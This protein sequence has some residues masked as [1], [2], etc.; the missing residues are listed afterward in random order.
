MSRNFDETLPQ[1]RTADLVSALP[2]QGRARDRQ[3]ADRRLHMHV[4]QGDQG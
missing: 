4:R 2:A 3:A 1:T